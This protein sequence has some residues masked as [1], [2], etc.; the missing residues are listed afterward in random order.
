MGGDWNVKRISNPAYKGFWEAKKV[1]NPEWVDDDQLYKY[2]EFGF[3][4]FDILQSKAG[5]IF[6]NI[7]IT[8]DVAEADNFAKKWKELSEVEKQMKKEDEDSKNSG[9]NKDEDDDDD[10]DDKKDSDDSD[11]V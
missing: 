8:D 1:A 4:R 5:T 11:E 3:V 2:D 6:D 10:P 9:D 7:I